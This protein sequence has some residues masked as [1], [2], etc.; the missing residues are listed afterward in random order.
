MRD[1]VLAFCKNMQQQAINAQDWATAQ[2]YQDMHSMWKERFDK[3]AA[4]D[5]KQAA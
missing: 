3:L 1:N 2:D 4:T 5:T